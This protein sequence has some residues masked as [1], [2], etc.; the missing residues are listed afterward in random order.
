L[1]FVC[2][3][4]ILDTVIGIHD[5]D[6]IARLF[7]SGRQPSQPGLC[8]PAIGKVAYRAAEKLVA[9]D[10]ERTDGQ[11]DREARAVLAAA[12]IRIDPAAAA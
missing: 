7:E 10:P 12:T 4:H 3:V 8:G 11:L 6:G 1:P 9:V 5:R 2:G